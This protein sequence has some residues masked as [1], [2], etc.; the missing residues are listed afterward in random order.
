MSIKKKYYKKKAPKER[1]SLVERKRRR[2]QKQH[3]TLNYHHTYC[4]VEGPETATQSAT[5]EVDP[6]RVEAEGRSDSPQQNSTV[7][8]SIPFSFFLL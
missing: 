4:K 5:E 7:K 2:L 1:T 8:I 6:Q 3:P